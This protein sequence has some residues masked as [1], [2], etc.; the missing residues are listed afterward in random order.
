M[1]ITN[2][3]GFAFRLQKLE[4]GQNEILALLRSGSSR[5]A[6]EVVNIAAYWILK[7]TN[8]HSV[9]VDLGR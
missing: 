1:T 4:D 8:C 2:A 9:V 7:F 5:D 3:A 6:P